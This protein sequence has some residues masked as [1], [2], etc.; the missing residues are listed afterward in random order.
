[1]LTIDYE[2][3]YQFLSYTCK[4]KYFEIPTTTYI[5]YRRL[6]DGWLEERE[7]KQWQTRDLCFYTI[8]PHRPKNSQINKP[9]DLW[10]IT[11]EEV[12]NAI[13]RTAPIKK[14]KKQ[15][16]LQNAFFKQLDQV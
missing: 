6:L 10:P 15:I 12:I 16:A 8:A 9:S 4:Y 3:G 2:R 1:M 11:Q 5:E 14:T 13:E 7:F